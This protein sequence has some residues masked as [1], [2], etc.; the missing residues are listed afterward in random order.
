MDLKK[1]DKECFLS[2]GILAMAGSS[3]TAASFSAS[4]RSALARHY[5]TDVAPAIC[6]HHST[7]PDGK[8]G[9]EADRRILPGY[10]PLY[11]HVEL[12]IVKAGLVGEE[13]GLTL[14]DGIGS[15]KFVDRLA[16]RVGD[17]EKEC[18]RYGTPPAT[19]HSTRQHAT[20]DM[21]LVFFLLIRFYE[22]ITMDA[23]RLIRAAM[24]PGHHAVISL[25][26]P[27]HPMMKAG[28]SVADSPPGAAGER[29]H[30]R[31]DQL[32]DTPTTQLAE[33]SF[34]IGT[35]WTLQ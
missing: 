28:Q 9:W 14:R 33:K 1:P 18:K 21:L 26:S 17:L 24:E 4:C 7:M 12:S 32:R 19:M 5:G 16:S 3:L 27:T 2:G 15:A 10:G 20:N 25:A 31:L 13:I 29:P 23:F 34:L 30:G 11:G 22:Q 6:H 35:C 8:I